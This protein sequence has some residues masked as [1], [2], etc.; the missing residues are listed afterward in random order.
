MECAILLC[1]DDRRPF[2]NTPALGW[3]QSYSS[4]TSRGLHCTTAAA[5][6]FRYTKGPSLVI[7]LLIAFHLVIVNREITLDIGSTGSRLPFLLPIGHLVFV[8]RGR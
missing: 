8:L 2:L 4:D 6:R 7:L 3:M 5:A 1:E